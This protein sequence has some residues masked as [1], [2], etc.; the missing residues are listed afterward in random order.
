M[1]VT[2]SLECKKRWYGQKPVLIYAIY[3]I[4]SFCSERAWTDTQFSY[5]T[6]VWTL[7][8]Q[9]ENNLKHNVSHV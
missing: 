6:H 5:T 7:Y 8:L 4:Q 3:S 9:K 1:S 2:I